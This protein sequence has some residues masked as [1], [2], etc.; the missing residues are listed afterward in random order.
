MPSAGATSL[1]AAGSSTSLR[2]TVSDRILTVYKAGE[3]RPD[4]GRS[5]R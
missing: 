5:Q 2:D 4:L 1:A 3:P